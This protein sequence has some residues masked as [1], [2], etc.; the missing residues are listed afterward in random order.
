V[1]IVEDEVL[2]NV[3]LHKPSRQSGT[4]GSHFANYGNDGNLNTYVLTARHSNPW[5][6]VDLGE[7]KFVYEVNLT[8]VNSTSGELKQTITICSGKFSKYA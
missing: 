7:E 1:C 5:W 2:L 3:A 8:N 4:V 6:S